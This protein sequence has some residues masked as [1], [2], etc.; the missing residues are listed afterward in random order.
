MPIKETHIDDEQSDSNEDDYNAAASSDDDGVNDSMNG[1]KTI[2]FGDTNMKHL[3]KNIRTNVIAQERVAAVQQQVVPQSRNQV[4][5][6]QK[7]SN[8]HHK[9]ISTVGGAQGHQLFGG[10][11]KSNQNNKIVNY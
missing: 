2:N 5:L 11:Q 4:H 10:P 1:R 6:T 3:R 8:S 7:R 9:I